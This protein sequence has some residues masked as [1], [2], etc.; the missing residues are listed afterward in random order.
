MKSY[1]RYL[2]TGIA[3][4]PSG[5]Y[6]V[7]LGKITVESML[8]QPFKAQIHLTALGS[9]PLSS[10]KVRLAHYQD[11]E[12]AG[13]ERPYFLSQL[14]FS[15][16]RSKRGK[17]IIVITSSER[18]A[19]PYLQFLVDV[20]WPKGQ[21]YRAYTVFLD[22]PDYQ[23]ALDA[24][25][26]KAK[27]QRAYPARGNKARLEPVKRLETPEAKNLK[28]DDSKTYSAVYGPV[29]PKETLRQ[30]AQK[31]K[32]QHAE[33]VQVM[34][35]ILKINPHAFKD[36]NMMGLMAGKTLKIPSYSIISE[37]SVEQAKEQLQ[38]QEKQWQE[39]QQI[40]PSSIPLPKWSSSI[41]TPHSQPKGANTQAQNL[42]RPYDSVMVPLKNIMPFKGFLKS[43]Q[44]N[45]NDSSTTNNPQPQEPLKTVP[46]K[47]QQDHIKQTELPLNNE[48]TQRL[49]Q[50]G[51]KNID[52]ERLVLS[53]SQEI[54]RL[55]AEVSKLSQQ[56]DKALSRQK[57]DAKPSS[58][59]S[60]AHDILL[61]LLILALLSAGGVALLF[62][63]QRHY[64]PH[65]DISDDEGSSGEP[66]DSSLD[67][68]ASEETKTPQPTTDGPKSCASK[69]DALDSEKSKQARDDKHQAFD[70][71]SKPK[72]FTPNQHALRQHE[73]AMDSHSAPA[74][75]P[76]SSHAINENPSK[77]N[78]SERD[79]IAY[80]EDQSNKPATP[81]LADE[82]F[83]Q[84]NEISIEPS[85]P[86][87]QSTR[88]SPDT[89]TDLEPTSP[90]ASQENDGEHVLEFEPGLGK[91][92]NSSN[93]PQTQPQPMAP[94]ES[95]DSAMD[96]EPERSN[97]FQKNTVETASTPLE[98]QP[99]ELPESFA[100]DE[101][102]DAP[103]NE[104]DMSLISDSDVLQ[105]KLDLA[106]AYI[107]MDDEEAARVLLEE[108]IQE[109][110]PQQQKIA[111]KL[112]NKR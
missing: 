3:F 41:S 92:F 88:S 71:P 98:I 110:N 46:V 42:N 63:W 112:L 107:N 4:I 95:I 22:P 5:V 31:F 10:I 78:D 33:L 62:W 57:Q 30:I 45:S 87:V 100:E 97:Q 86:P 83:S 75:V 12:R 82:F 43:S 76:V 2:I 106:Q 24:E 111:K 59:S 34:V 73:E 28:I 40:S 15:V 13:L 70:A 35:A 49:K 68:K 102:F 47:N 77:E 29:K 61:A 58:K 25:F 21:F 72:S 55:K 14:K 81:R 18:M 11:F 27:T 52:L 74:P 1:C 66:Q 37:L 6:A 26:K 96:E 104:Q 19:E 93:A 84:E 44:A 91:A 64:K 23:K 103:P 85:A 50:I 36:Q 51:E 17:G 65:F 48:I 90:H 80:Q 69:Q 99:L 20:A 16:Q 105:T 89:D 9:T 54:E 94:D 39:K 8:N 67:L 101:P 53:K 108:V 32:P 7:G 56:F 109:G 60:V 38:M 79:S